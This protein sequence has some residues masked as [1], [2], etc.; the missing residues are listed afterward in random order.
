MKAQVKEIRA[1]EILSTGGYPTLEAVVTLESG[2]VGVAS[3]PYGTSAGRYEAVTLADGDPR[4][5][6]GKGMLKAVQN[7][8]DVIAP[9]IRGLDV[10]NQ[11]VID[12]HLIALLFTHFVHKTQPRRVPCSMTYRPTFSMKKLNLHTLLQSPAL[13]YTHSN[14]YFVSQANQ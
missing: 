9:K 10:L 1:R 3:V 8:N 7:V 4:R 12:E 2:A 14:W 6:R 5:Y 13:N 11:H